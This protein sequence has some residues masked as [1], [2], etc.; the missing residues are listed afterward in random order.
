M[1]TY[2]HITQAVQ[3]AGA[4][5]QAYISADQ[6]TAAC[7]GVGKRLCTLDEWMLGCQGR[8]GYV[9]PYGNTYNAS[10]CNEARTLNPVIELFVRCSG[11]PDWLANHA[12]HDYTVVS[13]QGPHAAFNWTELNDPAIDLLANT[14]GTIARVWN[15]R[16]VSGCALCC[17][18]MCCV[19]FALCS[20]CWKLL[21]LRQPLG[22]VR[23]GWQR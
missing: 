17:H 13:L 7:A 20:A 12:P 2:T 11:P 19:G 21:R 15:V 10:A 1:Y 9:Y 18:L 22:S 4:M 16:Q 14:V 3:E 23:Y 6:A 8:Q 5:P